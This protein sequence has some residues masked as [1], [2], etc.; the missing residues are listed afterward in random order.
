[1]VGC[2]SALL[3]HPS[4]ASTLHIAAPASA[5]PRPSHTAAPLV[6]GLS[7][8]RPQS[9]FSRDL[10]VLSASLRRQELGGSLQV[11]DLMAG[12]GVRGMRYLQHSQAGLVWCNDCSPNT[13]TSL[14]TNL[15][16]AVVAAHP[17]AQA[18]LASGPAQVLLPML[19]QPAWDW[20]LPV[21]AGSEGIHDP[22]SAS[23]AGPAPAARL[24]HEEG[25]RSGAHMLCMDR[26]FLCPDKTL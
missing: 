20:R 1:M 10:A 7:F 4:Q 9:I 24:T 14:V 8:F 5:P 12:S 3:S 16:S 25:S 21:E 2:R 11:L 6:A 23:E 15:S 18:A 17:A 19:D 13:H 26:P 22:G